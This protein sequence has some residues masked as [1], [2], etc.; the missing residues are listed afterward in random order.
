MCEQVDKVQTHLGRR[1]LI[2][3][4]SAYLQFKESHFSEAQFLTELCQRTGAQILLDINN[5]AVNSVNFEGGD[6]KQ[7]V[8]NYIHQLPLSRKTT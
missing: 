2:E 6:I 4:V 7:S 1:L 5:I 8:H 3:N